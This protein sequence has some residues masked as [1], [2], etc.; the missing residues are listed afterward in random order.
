MWGGPSWCQMGRHCLPIGRIT[1]PLGVL[2]W[3]CRRFNLFFCLPQFLGRGASRRLT[4]VPLGRELVSSY[5][6]VNTNHHGRPIWYR[7][8]AIC[9]AGFDL[10]KGWS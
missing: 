6:A 5:K 7:L 10:G 2:L 1:K 8:A 3:F 9:D 4:M